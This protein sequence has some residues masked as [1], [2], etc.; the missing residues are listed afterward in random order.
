MDL[1]RR[2]LVIDSFEEM[3]LLVVRTLRRVF[4][5]A[6]VFEAHDFEDALR[7]ITFEHYDAI[8]VHRAI[9][10]DAIT[11]IRCIRQHRTTVPIV[12]VSS[13]D[14]TD[15]VLAAGA[16]V[17]L[18]FEEWLRVGTVVAELVSRAQD[19]VH[20]TQKGVSAEVE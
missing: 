7:L 10:A 6:T 1:P 16:N 11:M 17:F 5:Q 2:F 20:V 4:P 8:V 9:G 14:R 12:A 3:R 15:A 13:I 18:N 19:R